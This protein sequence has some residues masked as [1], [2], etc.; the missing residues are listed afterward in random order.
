MYE[1]TGGLIGD[2]PLVRDVVM[3]PSGTNG[4]APDAYYSRLGLGLPDCRFEISANMT[5][6]LRPGPDSNFKATVQ[7]GGGPPVNMTGPRNGPWTASQVR[8]DETGP[9]DVIIAWEW[10][11]KGPG[12]W[13]GDNCNQG[14]GCDQSGSII[15]H[16]ANLADDPAGNDDSPSEV[17]GAVKLTAGPTITSQEVHSSPVNQT[18]TPYVTIGLRSAYAPGDFA[19]LRLRSGQRNFSVICDPFW[20]QPSSQD[21]SAAFYFGCQPPY[22]PNDTTQNTFWWNT[23]TE[24]CPSAGSWFS[25]AG[26]PPNVTYPNAPWRCVQLDVGG[27]GFTVSDGIALRT[28]NC[29]NP[30]VDS[31]PAPGAKADCQASR[32]TCNNPINYSGGPNFPSAEDPRV[33]QLY[34]VPYGAYKGVKSGNKQVV[35]VLQLAAFYITGWKFNRGVDP[36]ANNDNDKL[37]EA[38][39]GGYFIKF[40]GPSGPVTDQVCDPDDITLCRVALTR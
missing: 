15:V 2:G 31:A 40:V 21:A 39:L 20:P 10:K 37:G 5:W 30:A 23:T 7:A 38:M 16:Q 12:S 28:G 26:S 17:V 33:V 18:I 1:P 19:V 25:Y 11:Y 8:V 32:Y 36:C 14:K 34:V 24:S 4:C 35:P 9:S 27:N 6:G 22:A 3:S 13:A 29:Q